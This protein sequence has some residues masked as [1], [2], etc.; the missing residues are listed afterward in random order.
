MTV[1]SEIQVFQS[2]CF[3]YFLW[4]LKQQEVVGSKNI[5]LMKRDVG[6]LEEENSIQCDAVGRSNWKHRC[7]SCSVS[8]TLLDHSL[9]CIEHLIYGII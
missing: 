6:E 5:L 4:P 2:I 7:V 9:I 3:A 8:Y 1:T